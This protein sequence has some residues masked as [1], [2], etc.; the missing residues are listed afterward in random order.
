MKNRTKYL[1]RNKKTRRKLKK[2]IEDE[3]RTDEVE[4]YLKKGLSYE[5][6]EMI[7]GICRELRLDGL[8]EDLN[9]DKD[10]LK[11]A[12]KTIVKLHPKSEEWPLMSNLY[13]NHEG[14]YKAETLMNQYH[15]SILR[16]GIIF[17]MEYG[18]KFIVEDLQNNRF[19]KQDI[20]RMSDDEIYEYCEENRQE[21]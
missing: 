19:S 5:E 4:E 17:G 11:K 16:D 21:I 10:E 9:I 20:M 7:M 2:M 14:K 6:F 3:N 13:R 12:K 15:D 1:L 8:F 18:K